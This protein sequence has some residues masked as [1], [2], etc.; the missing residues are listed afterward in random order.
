M[1]IM[2]I[3]TIHVATHVHILTYYRLTLPPVTDTTSKHSNV[4]M[5]VDM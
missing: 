1:L 3:I 5:I 2:L 4:V